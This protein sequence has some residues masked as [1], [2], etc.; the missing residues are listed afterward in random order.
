MWRR[1]RHAVRRAA[2]LTATFAYAHAEAR[3]ELCAFVD[4]ELIGIEDVDVGVEAD[5]EIGQPIATRKGGRAGAHD[6]DGASQCRDTGECSSP[7]PGEVPQAPLRPSLCSAESSLDSLFPVWKASNDGLDAAQWTGSL[8]PRPSLI[9]RLAT[10]RRAMVAD[11]HGCL[12][13]VL[14]ESRQQQR[15]AEEYLAGLKKVDSRAVQDARTEMVAVAVLKSEE[16]MLQRLVRGGLLEEKEVDEEFDKVE[17][18]MKNMH[19]MYS[20]D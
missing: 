17:R 16:A 1:Q 2:T 15:G 5:P 20:L 14:E 11:L 19:E 18:R 13:N 6:G 4:L 10:R 8:S 9:P 12:E 3:K 7:P